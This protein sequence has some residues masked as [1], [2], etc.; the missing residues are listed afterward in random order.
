MPEDLHSPDKSIKQIEKEQKKLENKQKDNP[1]RIG[2]LSL[3]PTPIQE[4]SVTPSRVIFLYI[5]CCMYYFVNTDKI[6]SI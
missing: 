3:K 5:L 4:P 2:I 6:V 1:R